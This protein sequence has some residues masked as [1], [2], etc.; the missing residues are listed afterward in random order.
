LNPR[1]LHIINSSKPVLVDFYADWCGPC[2]E[3]SPILKKVKEELK[4]VKIVK[5]NVDKN[6]FIASHFKVQRIPTLIIFRKGE[7]LWTG[8]GVYSADELKSILRGR[9]EDN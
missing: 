5:V 6:P 2:K 8:E 3:V 1:F 4:E 7:P 9:L